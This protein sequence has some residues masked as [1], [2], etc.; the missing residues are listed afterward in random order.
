MRAVVF[1]EASVFSARLY[2]V[3]SRIDQ[4]SCLFLFSGA[5]AKLQ[6]AAISFVLTFANLQL[7]A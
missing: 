5:Q 7:D 2:G 3:S 4:Y 6:K 1:S